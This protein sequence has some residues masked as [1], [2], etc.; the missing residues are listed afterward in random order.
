MTTPFNMFVTPLP[1]AFFR[2][3]FMELSLKIQ[4]FATSSLGLLMLFLFAKFFFLL[5]YFIFFVSPFLAK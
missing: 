3:T 1:Q 4:T 5:F 2:V